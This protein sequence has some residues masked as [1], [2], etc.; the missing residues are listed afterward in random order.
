[1]CTQDVITKSRPL[2]LA[3]EN[4]R[5]HRKGK[6]ATKQLEIFTYRV[7][8]ITFLK[9]QVVGRVLRDSFTYLIHRI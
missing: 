6:Y 4:K 3:L 1:M 9:R 8:Y 7:C 5:T 2:A